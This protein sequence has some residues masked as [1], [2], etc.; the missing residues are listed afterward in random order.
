MKIKNKNIFLTIFFF[1]ITLIIFIFSSAPF[2]LI[3]TKGDISLLEKKLI[4][5]SIILMLIIIIPVIYITI[6]FFLKYNE[7]EKKIYKPN[8]CNSKKI[9]FLIWTIPII[10]I[11]ILG[12]ITLKTTHVLDPYKPLI[13]CNEPIEIEVISL[14]WKWLFIYPNNKIATINEICFPKNTPIKFKITSNSVM[15]SFFIPKLGSQIYSMA[16]M[17]S[18]LN[19]ISNESGNYEGFSS[20]FSGKG[21]SNM[22]FKVIVTENNN[23]FKKWLNIVKMSKKTI[24]NN[25]Q[26]YYISKQSENNPIEYYSN[27][28]NN[29]FKKIILN[30]IK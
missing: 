28:E 2:F 11:L 26:F 27:V 9:E 15:N 20:S 13:N 6:F 5:T 3:K 14:D 25:R 18:K 24:L 19:L 23:E 30:F 16:G 1:I 21:F 29:L 4:I 12:T 17:E 8:W 7:K 10:I 22:K